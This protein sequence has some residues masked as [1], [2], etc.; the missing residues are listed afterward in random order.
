MNLRLFFDV[1]ARFKYL[2]AAGLIV[3]FA[4]AALSHVRVSLDGSKVHFEYRAEERWQ[5]TATLFVTQDGFPW[6]RSVLDEVVPVG[7]EGDAGYVPRYSDVNRF[8]TLAHLYA[9]LA[10]G[11]DVR[12]IMRRDGPIGGRYEAGLVRSEDGSASLPLVAIAGIGPT[13]QRAEAIAR[14]ATDAFLL[15]LRRA[16]E[17]NRIPQAKRVE[18]EVVKQPRRAELVQGR[19]MTRPVFLFVLAMSAVVAL[20][21]AL[22]NLRPRLPR[23]ELQASPRAT[24]VVPVERRTA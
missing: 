23:A 19:R 3:A 24:P 22:E 11:D 20:A 2:V 4:L 7:P 8:Q 1:L 5:S 21:F 10:M 15:F 6:G 12:A 13:P 14:R 18:I 16:Q 17:S 9:Q